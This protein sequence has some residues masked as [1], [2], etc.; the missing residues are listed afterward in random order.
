[1]QGQQEQPKK[2]VAGG[3]GGGKGAGSKPLSQ[4]RDS[5]PAHSLEEIQGKVAHYQKLLGDTPDEAAFA[6]I[7]QVLQAELEKWKKK[8][9]KQEQ[10]PE[11]DLQKLLS[12]QVQIRA[13]LSQ[14]KKDFERLTNAIQKI[15]EELKQLFETSHNLQ[16][17]IEALQPQ[18]EDA[19]MTKLKRKLDEVVGDVPPDEENMEEDDC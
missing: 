16:L 14:K 2:E 5:P 4:Q 6:D 13:T 8:E 11:K 18:G 17:E 9:T 12:Q 10:Q 3:K 1:M 15:K 7:R 19:E